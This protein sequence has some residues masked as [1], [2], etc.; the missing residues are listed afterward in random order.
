MDK[1]AFLSMDVE[2]YFDTSSIRELEFEKDSRYNCASEILT[3]LK[4]F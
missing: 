2:S 4:L 3:F 1:V